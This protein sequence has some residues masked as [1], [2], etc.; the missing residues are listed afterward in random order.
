MRNWDTSKWKHTDWSY[1]AAGNADTANAARATLF[2]EPTYDPSVFRFIAGTR[3]R[4]IGWEST[5]DVLDKYV[6][7]S[8]A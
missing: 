3:W 1:V 6:G 2:I 7:A 8:A 5:I 4:R